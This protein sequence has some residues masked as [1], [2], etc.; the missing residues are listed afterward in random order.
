MPISDY[1]L[2][3]ALAMHPANGPSVTLSA[4][5]L[6]QP[7]GG[8][9]LV[10]VTDVNVTHKKTTDAGSKDPV[11]PQFVITGNNHLKTTSG[12]TTTKVLTKTGPHKDAP[13]KPKHKHIAGVKYED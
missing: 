7:A 5:A 3:L 1:L 8:A 10:R 2:S 6:G 11:T 12:P 13:A 9:S 4:D